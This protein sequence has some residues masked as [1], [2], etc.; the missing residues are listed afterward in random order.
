MDVTTIARQDSPISCA[1]PCASALIAHSH[2]ELEPFPPA[3]R[4][5]NHSLRLVAQIVGAK[6][7]GGQH[8]VD[9]EGAAKRLGALGANPV[10]LDFGD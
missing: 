2:L 10:V 1:P 7:E 5:P 3:H 4:I 8:P 9:C 6:V